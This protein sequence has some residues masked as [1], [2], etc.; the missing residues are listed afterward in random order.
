MLSGFLLPYHG[1]SSD[2][3]WIRRLPDMEGIIIIII[4]IIIICGVGLS[5]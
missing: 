4:I 1:A 3:G 2:C 5:P